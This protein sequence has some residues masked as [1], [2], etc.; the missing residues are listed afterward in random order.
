[1]KEPPTYSLPAPEKMIRDAEPEEMILPEMVTVP[2]EIK[3]WLAR[4]SLVVADR[5]TDAAEKVPAATLIWFML[6]PLACSCMVTAPLTVNEEVLEAR[7]IEDKP[8]VP[9]VKFMELHEAE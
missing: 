8:V 2:V 1:M 7:L 6:P 5:A 4:E 9:V 3:I